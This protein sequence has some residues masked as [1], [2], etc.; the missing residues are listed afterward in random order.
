MSVG[1]SGATLVSLQNTVITNKATTTK[2]SGSN[3]VVPA[4]SA[5]AHEENGPTSLFV[6]CNESACATPTPNC[7]YDTSHQNPV[8]STSKVSYCSTSAETAYNDCCRNVP[9]TKDELSTAV[10]VISSTKQLQQPR[11]GKDEGFPEVRPR[12]CS[13]SEK[14]I[15]FDGVTSYPSSGHSVDVI[16]LAVYGIA[17]PGKTVKLHTHLTC[18]LC[19]LPENICREPNPLFVFSNLVVISLLMLVKVSFARKAVM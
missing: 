18:N 16:K 10:S 5:V 12:I 1:S 2:A 9:A 19:V 3:S 13:F 17:T 7:A 14:E 11:C 8:I 6:N 4:S 15:I